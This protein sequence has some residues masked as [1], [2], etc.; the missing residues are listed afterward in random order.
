MNNLEDDLF[1]TSAF[2]M[3]GMSS[4]AICHCHLFEGMIEISR[5]HPCQ[6]IGSFQCLYSPDAF[7]EGVSSFEANLALTREQRILAGRGYSIII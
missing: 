4:E 6:P 1:E 2:Y 7:A 5:N 3:K